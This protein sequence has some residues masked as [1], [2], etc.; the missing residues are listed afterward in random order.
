MSEF[1]VKNNFTSQ[2]KSEIQHHDLSRKNSDGQFLL[3]NIQSDCP[4]S[5]FINFSQ[6]NKYAHSSN[7]ERVKLVLK[8]VFLS[9]AIGNFK[10]IFFTLKVSF[11]KLRQ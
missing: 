8:N 9:K 10:A 6:E 3:R 5:K 2:S 7:D 4:K 11:G 1:I